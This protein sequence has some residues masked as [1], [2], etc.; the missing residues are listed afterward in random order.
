MEAR[1]ETFLRVKQAESSDGERWITAW[2]ST[3]DEDLA[4]DVVSPTGAQYQ[5]PIPLL[6]YHK[7]DSPVGVVTE[8]HVSERG[9]RVRAKL[10][11]GVRLADEVWQLVKDGAI[12]AVSIGFRALK[13]KPLP[14]GGLLFES[15]RWLEL[16]LTPV[17]CNPGA[18]I[19][20]VGKA[21]AYA[22][23]PEAPAPLPTYVPARDIGEDYQRAVATLPADARRIVSDLQ[24]S[25]QAGR[26]T[27]CDRHGAVV[28]TVPPPEQPKAVKAAPR[29]AGFDGARFA[30]SI[31]DYIQQTCKEVH[32]VGQETLEGFAKE[33]GVELK[34]LSVRIER[35]EQAN[36]EKGIRFR[37]FYRDGMEARTGDAVTHDGSLWIAVR[38]TNEAPSP[39]SP[40]WCLAARKGRD[41]R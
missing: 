10:S 1:H 5:L 32:D 24:S 7:T 14:S 6:A 39:G 13:S 16:S 33:V 38:G 23:T 8:A 2:A 34:K 11:K 41:G 29:P 31:R 30:A 36:A 20:S 3:P 35:I 15:W 25:K 37:G 26:W 12:A 22:T 40:D 19:V 4:G 18:R 17:P 21:I 9:I 27:L 28:A